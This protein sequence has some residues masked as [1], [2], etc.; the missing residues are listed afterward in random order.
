MTAKNNRGR[1]ALDL[2]PN[3]TVKAIIE[4]CITECGGR[5][6]PF[7]EQMKKFKRGGIKKAKVLGMNIG[8]DALKSI[9]NQNRRYGRQRTTRAAHL[10]LDGDGV[11]WTM[12]RQTSCT[13]GK[14]QYKPTSSTTSVV[15]ACPTS[16]LT[17]AWATT[18][19]FFRR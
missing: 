17:L 8:G 14:R 3:G 10:D 15:S 12:H 9:Q 2:A 11:L 6:Q 1:E 5:E 13:S 16:A 7:G 19:C 18:T 4:R